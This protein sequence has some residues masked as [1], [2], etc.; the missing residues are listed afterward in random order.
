MSQKLPFLTAVAPTY[1]HPELLASSLALWLAQDYPLD[2]RQM[3]ILDDGGTFYCQSGEGF[4]LW[5]NE[6]RYPSLSA[7]YNELLTL[8]PEETDYVF[9]WEDDDTYLP[10]YLRWHLKA[11]EGNEFSKPARV[12]SDYNRPKTGKVQEEGAQGRFHS[13]MAFSKDLIMRIGGWPETDKKEFDQMLISK[14]IENAKG[15]GDPCQHGPIQ[16]IYGWN[17]GAAHCQSTMHLDD[18][19]YQAAPKAYKEVPFVGQLKPNYDKRTLS[20]LKELNVK[21]KEYAA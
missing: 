15:V 2:R 3:I 8:M 9:I 21:V 20:I 1:R 11:L 7:K 10:S 5:S 14:L 6:E 18:K 13:S 17:T 12:Y 19:W 4:I 16:Y